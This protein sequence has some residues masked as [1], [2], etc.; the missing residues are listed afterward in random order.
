[1]T[2]KPYPIVPFTTGLERDKQPFLLENDAFPQL[3]NCYLYQ[4]R[5]ERRLGNKLL[6]RL[7][8]SVEAAA[9]GNT[10]ASPFTANLITAVPL[11]ALGISPGSVVINIAAPVGPLTYTDNGSG[12][13]TAP[14]P[15]IGT[16]NYQTGAIS[17][18]HPAAAASVVTANFDYFSGL[19]VMGLPTEET[20]SINKEDTK[21][22]DTRKANYYDIALGRFV[23]ISFDLNTLSPIQW[24]GSNSDFFWSWNYYY[25]FDS[26]GASRPL[27][28]TTNNV[29][30]SRPGGAGTPILDGIQV[31]NELGWTAQ[32]PVLTAPP[33][34][35][36]TN[37]LRGCLILVSYRNRMVALNTKESIGGFGV[38]ALY[39]NRARW[40]QNGVPFTDGGVDLVG[41]DATAWRQDIVGKGGYIDAPTSEQIVSCGFFK[42]TLVVF[43]ERSTWQLFY[44]GN[45]IL[46]FAWQ[47]LN[48]QWGCE[49][50]HSVISFDK[51]IFAVGNTA[52]V[53]SDSVNVERIDLKIPTDVF[54]FHNE[55][56]GPKRVYGIRDYFYQFCYWTFP[57]DD[58]N[59]IFPNKV[60]VLNY[61]DGSYSFYD[62]SYTCFGY[63]Q[64]ASDLIWSKATFP[65]QTGG[66]RTWSSSWSQSESPTVVAGNQQGFVMLIDQ[67]TSNEPTLYITAISQEASALVTSPNHNL[68]VNQYVKFSGVLGMTGINDLVGKIVA[69]V[70][71]NQFRVDINTTA[72]AAYTTSGFLTLINSYEVITK[73]FNP[74]YTDGQKVRSSYADFY[75]DR[76][77]AG[78]FTVDF[79]VDDGDFDA[80]DPSAPLSTSINTLPVST[81]KEYG[82]STTVGK[83]WQRSYPDCAGQYLQMRAYLSESQIRT[84]QGTTPE[85]YKEANPSQSDIIIHAINF[86]MAPSGRLQSY[87]TV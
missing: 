8:H 76:T 38:A 11:A 73:K 46:P 44:T 81:A 52:I 12:V 51:G 75:V 77:T 6:G 35:P 79:I 60:L 16:V 19:P 20:T 59:G 48:T 9:L 32:Y 82:P 87:D 14:G 57:N 43:F 36:T 56:N 86:W 71:A 62:D 45:E 78:A 49:S 80:T 67:Q 53:T 2:F 25:A 30:N 17:V 41:A 64:L 74:F 65:W 10:G 1:M 27:F 63:Y 61:L 29:A 84:P 15:F 47:R 31:Y 26:S 50:T 83:I 18:N 22:F 69:R 42:D 58:Q 24:N 37:Y 33:E 34:T 13:L 85:T 21:A 40:S 66:T 54:E 4:G 3:S 28:W 72:M 23:D 5:V 68:Y 39:G 55:N 7:V 70:N